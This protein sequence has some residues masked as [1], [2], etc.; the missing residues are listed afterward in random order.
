MQNSSSFLIILLQTLFVIYISC[1]V[2]NQV[3]LD[4]RIEYQN[5]NLLFSKGLYCTSRNHHP[6]FPLLVPS[7]GNGYVST[8]VGSETVFVGG[9]FSG[10]NYNGL[11]MTPASHR[12]RI[13][14]YLNVNITNGVVDYVDRFGDEQEVHLG[15]FAID[16][17]RG[18]FFERFF[19]GM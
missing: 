18:V 9:L 11:D 10:R 5:D 2:I 12:A 1:S 6:S 19:V 7:I 17:K 15:G 4:W 14:A 16:V 3:P 13:P 8:V